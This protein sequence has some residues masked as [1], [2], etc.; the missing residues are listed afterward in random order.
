MIALK[1]ERLIISDHI[2]DDLEAIHKLLSDPAAMY[3]LGCRIAR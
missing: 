1:T 2:P 3:Y